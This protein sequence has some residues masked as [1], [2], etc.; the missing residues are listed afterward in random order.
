MKF[1]D[2]KIPSQK[3]I[4]DSCFPKQNI[5]NCLNFFRPLGRFPSRRLKNCETFNTS[6]YRKFMITSIHSKE[7]K[8]VRALVN[9]FMN[10]PAVERISSLYAEFRRYENIMKK[11]IFKIVCY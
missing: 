3:V 8:Q 5:Q 9:F 4:K 6:H 2:T 11:Y 10:E 1:D 7:H